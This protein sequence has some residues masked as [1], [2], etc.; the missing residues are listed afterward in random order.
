M[1]IYDLVHLII[2]HTHA[3]AGSYVIGAGVHLYIWYDPKKS[4]NDSLE[5]DSPF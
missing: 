1:K 4:L 2:L 5:V 3:Q